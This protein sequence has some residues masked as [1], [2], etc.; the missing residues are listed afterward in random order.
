MKTILVTGGAGYLGCR[1]VNDLIN[2]FK[3]RIIVFDNFSR[4]KLEAIGSLLDFHKNNLVIIPSEH[5]DI[6]DNNNFKK[7]LINYQPEVVINLASIM[8]AFQTNREGK[9]RECEIVN[10]ESA[11]ENAKIAK[12]VGVKIFICQSSVSV[13]S[14]GEEIKEDSPTNPLSVYGMAKFKAGKEIRG[15]SDEN[16]KTCVLR[17][18]TYVGYSPGFTYQ[19]IVNLACIR[20][21]YNIPINI[22]ESA[23]ENNKT[24]LDIKDESA[25]IIFA[26]ENIDQ[27]KGEIF[28]VASFHANLKEVIAL[29]EKELGREIK[30]NIVK[31]NTINQ[32][33]YT[34]NSDKIKSLG[35][36]PKGQLDIII[37]ETLKY[38]TIRKEGFIFPDDSNI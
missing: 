27:M 28:N 6:R 35:F 23:L 2:K 9:D 12:E 10:Y 31:E 7:A 16:F 24:Y 4:G 34:I 13:Y 11:V 5:G 29:I 30:K 18:A 21:L 14:R 37:H 3:C 38:L 17:A 26:I 33:V 1:L 36:R 19:T 22:F 25:A 8:D 20:A 32:Q 15:L